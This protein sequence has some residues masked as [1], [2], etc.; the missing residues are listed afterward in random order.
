MFLI[1]IVL[2]KVYA[3]Y[4][5]YRGKI[6]EGLVYAHFVHYRVRISEGV[7]TSPY[8]CRVRVSEG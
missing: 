6:S 3:K 5:P 8:T 1:G 4:V 2:V 7:C